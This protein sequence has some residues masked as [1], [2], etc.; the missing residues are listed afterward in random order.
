MKARLIKKKDVVAYEAILSQ[1]KGAK[2]AP[3]RD[4]AEIKVEPS[5]FDVTPSLESNYGLLRDA[6][7]AGIVAWLKTQR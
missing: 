4:V 6:R 7:Q 1:R 2:L 5:G 3:M